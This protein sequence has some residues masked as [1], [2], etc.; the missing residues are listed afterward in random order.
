MT[1]TDTSK[2]TTTDFGEGPVKLLYC[3]IYFAVTGTL[4][5]FIGR[6]V[7]KTVFKYDRFPFKS[8][9]FENNGKIYTKIGINKWQNKVPDMSKV[10]KKL[11]PA[12]NLCGSVDS[13]R[14]M[15]M[16]LETCEAEV[17]HF[18]LCLTGLY[19]LWIWPGA[20]GA[21]VYAVYV[22]L[23]NLPFILIQ[24]YNRPRLVKLYLKSTKAAAKE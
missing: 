16:I 17:T 24:R 22:L 1:T 2:L 6:A 8:F 14:L 11:M 21:I 7:P 23:G 5:F 10:F 15:V 19:C 12:K 9:G 13:K 3:A 20:G 18:L 4:F